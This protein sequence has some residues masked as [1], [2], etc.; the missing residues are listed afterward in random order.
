MVEGMLPL[1][2]F[3]TKDIDRRGWMRNSSGG[4][5]PV[6][7]LSAMLKVTS[8]DNEVDAGNSGGKDPENEFAESISECRLGMARSED[9][10]FPVSML[11]S[12]DRPFSK[13]NKEIAWEMFPEK[14]LN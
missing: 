1:K 14:K 12:S 8:E 3:F 9:G 11:K 2:Q 10:M 13:L 5:V 4:M 7:P 6:R